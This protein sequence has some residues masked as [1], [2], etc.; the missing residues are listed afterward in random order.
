M[1]VVDAGN[2]RVQ[3]FDGDGNFI[4]QFGACGSA[5]GEFGWACFG[6]ETI[7]GIAVGLDGSVYVADNGNQRIQQF[8]AD[9]TFVRAWGWDVVGSGPGDDTIDPVGEFEICVAADGDLCQA[10]VGGSEAG[11][12]NNPV[13]IAVDPTDGDVL[14]ADRDNT[15]IQRFDSTGHYE[16]QFPTDGV[17]PHRVAVDSSGSIYVA[18]YQTTLQKYDSTGT[19]IDP[20]Y[21]SPH[22]ASPEDL[23]T[24]GDRVFVAQMSGNPVVLEFDST[25][26]GDQLVETHPV[27]TNSDTNYGVFGL[28]AH[29][30]SG[31]VYIDT[32]IANAA[33][34][35]FSRVFIL[36][37]G[38]VPPAIVTLLP[39]V[40]EARTATLSVEINSN[41]GLP[42]DYRI[43]ISPD[44]INWTTVDTGSVPKGN[45]DTLVT[46]QATELRPNTLYRF[47][48]ITNKGV[49][50][51]DVTSPESTFL[52]DPAPP[53]ILATRATSVDVTSATLQGRINPNSSPTS[54][55]FD[56]GINTFNRSIPVPNAQIGAGPDPVFVSRALRGLRPNT[57]YQFRLVATNPHGTTTSSTKIFTTTRSLPDKRA[58]E[59]VSPADKVSGVGV[60][61]WYAHAA[62]V[63]NTGVAAHQRERFAVQGTQGATL[64]DD[65]AY[66]FAND[67]TFAER[68]ADGWTNRPGISRRAHGPQLYTFAHLHTANDDLS[69]TS[70][71]SNSHILRLFPE[72]ES[73]DDTNGMVKPLRRWSEEGW[74]IFDPIDPAQRDIAI[75]GSQLAD[76][77]TGIAADGSAIVASGVGVRGLA[78]PRDPTRPVWADLA[79]TPLC[80]SS[81]YLDEV[82]G[83]FSDTFPGDDGR[84]ELVNVCTGSGAGRTLLPSGPCPELPDRDTLISS[85]GGSLSPSDNPVNGRVISDDG[86]RVFF[87]SPDPR[88]TG[89]SGGSAQQ[90]AQ[91][92][93]RQRNPDGTIVTRWISRS[94]VAGQPDSLID[95]AYFEGASRDGDKVFFRTAS[96]LTDDDPNGTCGA[97][98]ATGTPDP[99]SADLYMY[100]LP[101]GN[102]PSGGELTRISAGPSGNG[103]CNSPAAPD[104]RSAGALRFVSDDGTRVYFTCA[105]PLPG[106]TNHADGTRTAPGGSTTSDDASNLYVYDAN[107]PT[108]LRWRFVARLPRESV[109]GRCATTASG[110]GSVLIADSNATGV[111][112]TSSMS[113]VSGVPDGSWITFFT[114][115]RVSIDDPD[116]ESGDVYGYDLS[117]AGELARL[118]APQGG[119][120]NPYLCAPPSNATQCFGDPGIGKDDGMPLARLGVAVRPGGA[121]LAFFESRS[122]LVPE[123]T[124][125]AYDVYQWGNGGLSLLSTGT[126]DTDGA[127]FVGN[128][129]SG[130]NVYFATRDQLTWQDRD[131]VLDIYTARIGGGVPEPSPPPACAA[132]ADACR[133]GGVASEA[134]QP[135][136]K[137]GASVGDAAPG[138]RAVLSVRRFSRAALR[139]AARTGALVVHVRTNKA[140]VVRV[141]ARARVSGRVTRVGSAR[142]R[143]AR[144]GLLK[145]RV[146]LSPRARMALRRRVALPVT[147]RVTLPGARPRSLTARLPGEKS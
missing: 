89:L 35:P 13:G 81:V 131:R 18:Q 133:D 91:V 24:A 107:G 86:S 92:Y 45:T 141:R 25:L 7:A 52:T 28:A 94:E 62:S 68:G 14:V 122:R 144:A 123:D 77:P 142:K 82:T 1:Y 60:G 29:A 21:G 104:L 20:A 125:D 79:C 109:L 115:G 93:V 12:F 106:V 83:P 101:A 96:P 75:G 9:G 134:P 49:N 47:R 58:Y 46:A 39:A 55:R 132:L 27:E 120:G 138:E 143:A 8:E 80:P 48:V 4:S 102:D 40:A 97:P 76:G 32:V 78:G 70:W 31:R 63:A 88:V 99:N 71:Y 56:Y 41:G 87:M 103:D 108:A 6:A 43:E 42:T 34:N 135:R 98:C 116:A 50:S 36:D 121:K 54:Y 117:G 85:G 111:N 74:E 72:M 100:D 145:L 67:W 64:S 30:S 126:S 3:R 129:R 118:S 37:D 84:R 22:V 2:D 137:S 69:L 17:S 16:S 57:T 114:D 128:D 19:L 44:G 95:P 136:T 147:L 90:D 33:G 15:R 130:T 110:I 146:K 65:G 140:G 73:W 113:C 119:I 66:S 5:G 38:G 105:A 127:M 11:Q 59:L 53:D 51:P 26:G 112:I 139:K 10:G 23:A 124:D 61:N